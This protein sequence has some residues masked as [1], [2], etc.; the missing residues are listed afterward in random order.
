MKI[1]L[2]ISELEDNE[3]KKICIGANKAAVDKG[4][5]LVIMPGKYLV[6]NDD[7]DEKHPYKFQNTALFKYATKLGFDAVVIDIERIGKNVAILKKEALLKSFFEIPFLTLTEQEGYVASKKIMS[8]H[9]YLEQQGYQ[10][11]CD[12][13]SYAETGKLSN[14]EPSC[15]FSFIEESEAKALSVISDIGTR[16]FNRKFEDEGLYK[17]MGQINTELGVKNCGL[18]LYDKKIRNTF[19][20]PWEFPDKIKIKSAIVDGTEIVTDNNTE[21]DTDGILNIFEN[22][23]PKVLVASN[24]FVGQYQLGLMITEFNPRILIDNYFDSLVGIVTITS[25]VSYLET[26]MEKTKKEL[27]EVQEELARDDSVLDHIGGQDYLTGGLNRRGFFAKAYDYLKENFEAG[28]YAV[29]AYIR[30]DSL[31]KINDVYGHNEG[32][33]AVREVAEILDIVFKDCIHGRIRGDEF[34]AIS[35]SSEEGMAENFREEMSSQNAAL[36]DRSKRYIN[37]LQYS[38]CEFSYED[39]LSLREMLKETDE[40]LQRVKGNF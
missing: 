1:G 25:R 28:K 4:I 14:E 24:I 20:H 7:I 12:A 10:A 13:V 5:T 38:V 26:E 40:S 29:V 18:F 35:V 33:Q 31:K 27:L 16:L 2:V 36:L 34:A 30:M 23:T 21:I 17:S 11:I 37:Y 6:N 19:K 39:N 15:V 22:G 3:V 8:D 32:D 9:G